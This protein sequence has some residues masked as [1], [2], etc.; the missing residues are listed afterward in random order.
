[1]AS[2]KCAKCEKTVYA[3][4]AVSALNK[5][6]H[7]ACFR[8]KHCDNVISLKSFAAIDGEP[9]C[10]PHYMALFKSKGNYSA[11]TGAGGANKS[12]SYNSSAGFKGM[13]AVINNVGN[14]S[15]NPPLKKAETVDKSTPVIE[16]DVVIKKYDVKPLLEEVKADHELKHTETEDKSAPV[17]E[18]VQIKKL[19][20]SKFLNAI[21][22]GPEAPLEKPNAVTDRSTPVVKIG[23]AVQTPCAKCGKNVYPIEKLVACNKTYHNACFRCKHCDGKLSLKGFATIDGEPYCKPHYLSLFKSKGTYAGIT[24]TAEGK[25]SSFNIQFQGVR[26]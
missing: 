26:H 15:N 5:T 11:I 10:K 8:C 13:N 6:F 7:K 25:S 9:Y 20:R 24:G 14:P 23:T 2:A 12:S 3:M 17:I 18:P 21:E 16:S 4:E 1:M 22:K 19:D